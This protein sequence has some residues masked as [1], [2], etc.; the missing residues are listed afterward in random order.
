[1]RDRLKELWE[2]QKHFDNIAFQNA[3]T[4]RED[5]TLHRKVALITE[6][7]ELYNELPDFKYCKKN[8]KNLLRQKTGY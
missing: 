6:I 2:R 8:D 7:G 4:T 5:T 1:M 3:A